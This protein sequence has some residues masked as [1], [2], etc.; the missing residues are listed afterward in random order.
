MAVINEIGD[1]FVFMQELR[2][3]NFLL[4]SQYN[5]KISRLC[6]D[7]TGTHNNQSCVRDISHAQRQN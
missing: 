7:K 5:L 4:I 2:A 3:K 6:F 1:K